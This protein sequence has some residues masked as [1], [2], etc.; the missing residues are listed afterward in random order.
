MNRISIPMIL[1]VAVTM[2][3]TLLIVAIGSFLLLLGEEL[4]EAIAV[5]AA[6]AIAGAVLI[7]CALA[8]RGGTQE[9]HTAHH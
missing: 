4:G 8:A 1:P 6:L 7:G 2:L 3:V 9:R 5:G